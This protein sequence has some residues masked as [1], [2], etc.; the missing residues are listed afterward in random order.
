MVQCGQET[1]RLSR[2]SLPSNFP[3]TCP[4]VSGVDN[5]SPCSPAVNRVSR[6]VPFACLARCEQRLSPDSYQATTSV[7]ALCSS[8]QPALAAAG[9]SISE[10]TSPVPQVRARFLG[11]NLG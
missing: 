8:H 2:T 3:R 10:L 4:R 5:S 11:A 7:V 1:A 6:P 9:A